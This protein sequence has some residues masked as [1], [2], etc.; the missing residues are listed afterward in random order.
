MAW[1]I[2]E[3]FGDGR[4]R[5]AS[6]ERNRDPILVVLEWVLPERGLV[7]EI[8]SGTGQH[9]VHFARALPRLIWQPDAEL[10]AFDPHWGVRDLE[11]VQRAA[12]SAGFALS[13]V[14]DMP[15]NNLSLVFR[16]TVLASA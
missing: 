5:A 11:D 13:E 3:T 16:K 12:S 1:R 2:G 7:L 4:C 6:A 14:I 10:R 9:V 15:A 8:G